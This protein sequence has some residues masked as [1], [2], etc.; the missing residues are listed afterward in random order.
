MGTHS[1]EIQDYQL[2]LNDFPHLSKGQA[3][4]I[5]SAWG[6]PYPVAAFKE[7]VTIMGRACENDLKRLSLL[8]NRLTRSP[9][10]FSE[11][12]TYQKMHSDFSGRCQQFEAQL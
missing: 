1:I 11:S 10:S 7:Y 8:K 3:L 9:A 6:L 5:S 12:K 4:F 2:K